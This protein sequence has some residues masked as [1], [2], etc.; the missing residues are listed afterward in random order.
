MPVNVKYLDGGKGVFATMSGHVTG[1]ELIAI[2]REVFA[3][4]LAVEPYLYSLVDCDDIEGMNL[5]TMQLRELAHE[6]VSASKNLP[7]YIVAIYAKND[8]PFALARMWQVFV[9]Q[10]GWETRVFRTRPEAVAW[11]KRLVLAK[12][13]VGVT[14]E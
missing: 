7:N 6:D 10:A 4:D 3:R 14:L 13:G 9:E 8:L 1:D 2:N 12:F 5:S 11:V